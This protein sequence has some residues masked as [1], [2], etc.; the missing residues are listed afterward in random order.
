M[1]FHYDK[2]EDALY[3]RFDESPYKESEEI[4]EGV[5]FDYN[6]KGEII[7]I[8]MLNASKKLSKRFRESFLKKKYPLVM[9]AR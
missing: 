8:E 5:V 6:R 9:P 1:R 4:R 7:G 3:I 2:I